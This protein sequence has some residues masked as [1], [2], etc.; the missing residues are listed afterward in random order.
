MLLFVDT[1]TET[2]TP[3]VGRAAVRVHEAAGY[4]VELASRPVCCGRPLFDHGLLDTARRQLTHLART[5]GPAA[6]AG[7]PIV[8]L[9]PSCVAALRDELTE[10]L[11]RD[12]DAVAVAGA[13]RT[14][15]EL[16]VEAGW[17]PP[18]LDGEVLVH[19]HCHH[20]AVMGMSADRRLLEAAGATWRD[21]DAGCCGLAGSFGFRAGDPYAVS[22]ASGERR[23]APAVRAAEPDAVL[24]AD[25]F[26]CRTQVEHLAPGSARPRHLAELLATALDGGPVR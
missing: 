3:E 8:G 5:F 9:E 11:P 26:S 14:L 1:F 21:L 17:E 13:T 18:H 23:L 20:E 19:G 15:A 16:L 12:A 4:R 2:L 24:L 22:V 7:V 25:G 10:M 6:R